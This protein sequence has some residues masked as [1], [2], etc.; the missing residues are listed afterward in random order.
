MPDDTHD[1]DHHDHHGHDHHD[2]HDHQNHGH[3]HGHDNDQGI[4]GALRYLRFAPKMWRSE[5]NT[6]VLDMVDPVG[7]ERVLDVGAGMGA[8]TVIA[9]RAGASVAAVE[10]TPFLRRVLQLRR[11]LQRNRSNIEII[12]GTA[13]RLGVDDDSIDAVWAVNTM[14][15]WVDVEQGV[16][17][18]ARVVRPGGRVVLVDEDF[19]DPAHPDHDR[20][21]S[22]NEGEHH[23]FTMVDATAMGTALSAVGLV[24]VDAEK[25][26]VGGRPAIVVTAAGSR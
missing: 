19:T 24:D 9:A 22:S 1:A 4:R 7:E 14:H 25:R 15:H 13:E 6:A 2:H 16:A 23:G 10:P 11:L 8:G 17:E 26:T 3:S 5:I 20:F 12:D 21:G 18:I